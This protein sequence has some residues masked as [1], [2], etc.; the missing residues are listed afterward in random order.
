[1]RHILITLVWTLLLS[2]PSLAT[3]QESQLGTANHL[4]LK[5][6][7]LQGKLS[8]LNMV[9]SGGCTPRRTHTM[10]YQ[11]SEFECYDMS[12]CTASGNYCGYGGS[13]MIAV[14]KAEDTKFSRKVANSNNSN[15]G[16]YGYI[17][18][19]G[20]LEKAPTTPAP[21][22]D[23]SS[24]ECSTPSAPACPPPACQSN[25]YLFFVKNF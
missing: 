4:L 16:R 10:Q 3:A 22:L 17:R 11:G 7:E 21:T 15:A 8:S 1:M 13:I 12:T 18:I 5:A 19:R 14:P 20:V 24:K 9:T 6:G 2:V 25:A 23:P